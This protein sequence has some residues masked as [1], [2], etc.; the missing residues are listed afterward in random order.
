MTLFQNLKPNDEI[1]IDKNIYIVLQN[2]PELLNSSSGDLEF[3]IHICPKDYKSLTASEKIVYNKN[4][5]TMIARYVRK[6]G[7]WVKVF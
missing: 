6:S 1:V 5:G 7:S 2:S 3:A 4:S